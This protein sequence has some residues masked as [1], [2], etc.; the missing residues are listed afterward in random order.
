MTQTR[1]YLVTADLGQET[2]ELRLIEA[3]SGSQ[4]IRHATKKRV[5][6]RPATTKEVA[7]LLSRG[8]KLEVVSEAGHESV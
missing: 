8:H 6:A 3:A 7:H 4:A 2:A 1:I 5:G